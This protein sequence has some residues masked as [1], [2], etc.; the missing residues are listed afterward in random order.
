[1]T[2]PRCLI[3]ALAIAFL[4]GC[5]TTSEPDVPSDEAEV[6][7][8]LLSLRVLDVGSSPVAGAIATVGPLGF[9]S[10]SDDA[11]LVTFRPLPGGT[12]RLTV[13][14]T[15]FATTVVEAVQL[16]AGGTIELDV[17]LPDADAGGGATLIVQ[18][19][20]A[21]G[22]PLSGASVS[23]DGGDFETSTDDDGRAVVWGL[24][25][26][27]FPVQ[28]LPAAGTSASPWSASVRLEEDAATLLTV[29]LSGAPSD[30]ATWSGSAVCLDCHAAE[31]SAWTSS[32]HGM[33]WSQ[34]PPSDLDALLTSGIS[35][36]IDLPGGQTVQ[37]QLARSGA[38]DQAT[39]IGLG[40]TATYDVLG[41]Y[42]ASG[43]VPLLDHPAG[44]AP[45]PVIWRPPG[46]GDLASP[47]FASGLVPFRADAWFQTRGWL[48]SHDD[49]DGPAPTDFE[50]AAC[51]GC[52]ATGFQIDE[53][54]GVVTA[55][56]VGERGVGCEACH[57]PGSEHVAAGGDQDGGVERIVNPARLDPQR[58]MDVCGA[59]HSRGLATAS[60][61]FEVEV[62]FPY[63]DHEG[64]RAGLVLADY[65]DPSPDLWQGGAAASP[66]QQVDELLASP[67]GGS[68]LYA[69]GCGECHTTHGPL[70]N[71]PHQLRADPTDN[72]LC[73]GC[74]LAL[75]FEDAE[76]A[77]AHTM[78]SG[79]D[80]AGVDSSGRCTGCHMPATAS[81]TERSELTGGGRLASHS[82]TAISPS[83]SLSAFDAVENAGLPLNEVPPNSCL[84]CHRWAETRYAEAGVDFHGP[85]GE[86]TLRTTYATLTAVYELFF[87][88]GE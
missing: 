55:S 76:S 36:S 4:V 46:T 27:D 77:A 64:W 31:H 82:F 52:H 11:G 20:T 9:E 6:L 58:S 75:H 65:L 3:A 35:A 18:T 10:T 84:T 22:R 21:A 43:V 42:G 16:P 47:A 2:G 7:T 19:S 70:E 68:G 33:T 87:G 80:P 62:Q 26:G 44:P 8:G 29:T 5:P 83:V 78:H 41:W 1:V 34:T 60:A 71:V 57:G 40:A 13:A 53:H 56:D 32:L 54:G 69:L 59:C 66:N 51:L 73:L 61:P 88:G 37:V 23:I 17:T 74:H 12:Y 24:S 72:S 28:I 81:R 14:A 15:G 67:H 38:V 45:G 50:A 25:A 30:A 48:I 49:T 79:Y 85:A 39:L 86:P 63:R